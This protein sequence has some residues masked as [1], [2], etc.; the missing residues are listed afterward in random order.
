MS[1]AP[2][3][4]MLIATNPEVMDQLTCIAVTPTPLE[5]A[6]PLVANLFINLAYSVETHPHITEPHLVKRLLDTSK[7]C[8]ETDRRG[9][10]DQTALR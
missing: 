9:N 3:C 8:H 5:E 2:S 1:E 10:H 6:R 4:R 7:I